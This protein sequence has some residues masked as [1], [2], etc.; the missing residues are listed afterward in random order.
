MK[1][2][3]AS[4]ETEIRNLEDRS[5]DLLAEMW[6]GK[7]A[8]ET[9][10]QM[11]TE[12]TANQTAE[13]NAFFAEY[14]ARNLRQIEKYANKYGRKR[15]MKHTLLRAAQVAAV[16]IAVFALA[17]GVAIAASPTVRVYLTKLLV[18]VSPQYTSLTLT[19]DTDN[20]MDVPAEW[21]G[22]YYPSIIP[23]GLVI[24]QLDSDAIESIVT[25]VFPESQLW[26]IIY[27]EMTDGS[28]NIDTENAVMTQVKV[29]GYD[30]TMSTKGDIVSIYWFDGN[31]LFFLAVRG[32]SE[33][34]VLMIANGLKKIK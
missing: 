6:V 16:W 25:Y 3:T 10:K 32:H 28:A 26:Q 30:A 7:K 11:E 18:E 34:D 23:E 24:G 12:Q 21:Q 27:E 33:E 14:D 20:Y 5:W 19:E 9:F 13:M 15:F 1:K 17:G 29:L 4:K 8:D 22:G 2:R 31:T